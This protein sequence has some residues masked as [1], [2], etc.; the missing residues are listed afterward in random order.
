MDGTTVSVRAVIKTRP[1]VGA[2][3]VYARKVVGASESISR[4]AQRLAGFQSKLEHGEWDRLY[5]GS[6]LDI[7]RANE[8]ARAR[9]I[10]PRSI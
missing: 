7:F 1:S 3:P 9:M 2:L 4:K 5:D 6:E 10:L 8:A